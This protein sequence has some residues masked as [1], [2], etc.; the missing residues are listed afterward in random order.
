MPFWKPDPYSL[1][2]LGHFILALLVHFGASAL[3][4][5]NS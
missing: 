1:T 5:S 2:A 4:E 3:Q